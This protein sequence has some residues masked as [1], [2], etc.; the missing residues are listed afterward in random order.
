[1]KDNTYIYHGTSPQAA[2]KA[3]REGIK[4]RVTTQLE[5]NWE[6]HPSLETMVYLTDSYAPYFAVQATPEDGTK[7][8]D[9]GTVLEIDASLL[10]SDLFYPDEDF[11]E[12]ATRGSTYEEIED[13]F[14]ECVADLSRVEDMAERTAYIR[15]NMVSFYGYADASMAGLGNCCY[16]G[17]IPAEAIRRVSTFKA[18]AMAMEA[19]EPF[20]S[21]ANYRFCGDKYRTINKWFFDELSEADLEKYSLGFAETKCEEHRAVMRFNLNQNRTTLS[22]EDNPHFAGK[23]LNQN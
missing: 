3:L 21:L 14:G 10:E 1:M 12:Q 17:T 22:I 19:Q 9:W 4:P 15:E 5:G 23:P 18:S 13:V 2:K 8:P 6:E 16:E 20:I 7:N 11:I